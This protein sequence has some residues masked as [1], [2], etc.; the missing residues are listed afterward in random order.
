MMH[1]YVIQDGFDH[2]DMEMFQ[3]SSEND[4]DLYVDSVSEFIRKCIGDV[5]HPVTLKKYHNQKPLIDGGIRAK[6][7]A[8]TTAFNHGKMTGNMV[9]YK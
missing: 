7:K 5:V 8:Q 3:A 9:G 2:A 1:A 6:L 4:K